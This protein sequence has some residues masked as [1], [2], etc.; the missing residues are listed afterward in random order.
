MDMSQM[1]HYMGLIA[2]NQPWNLLIFMAI[3][4]IMAETLVAT[5]FFVVF[6]RLTAGSLRTFNK[7][8]GIVL[9]LYFA[10]IIVKMLT[11]V[12][13][14]EWNTWVDVVAVWAYILGGVPLV[15]VALMEM[16]L[17]FRGR[18]ESDKMRIHFLLITAFLVL[19]HVAMIFGMVNPTIITGSAPHGHM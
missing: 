19:G 10:G 1:T 2:D 9:G 11:I 14:I 13:G 4:V 17:L 5:E 3:P 16:G 18:S 6:G 15:G 8:L 7:Y 12:P